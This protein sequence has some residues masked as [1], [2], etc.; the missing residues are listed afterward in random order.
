MAPER[1]NRLARPL[2]NRTDNITVRVFS[3]PE[4]NV[5]RPLIFLYG[6]H[7][8]AGSSVLKSCAG[9]RLKR[10]KKA[11]KVIYRV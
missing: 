1:V 7:K 8:R 11:L 5:Y 4:I 10:N 6:S 9:F 3:L 2:A